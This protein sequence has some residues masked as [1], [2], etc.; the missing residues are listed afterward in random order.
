MT[1]TAMRVVAYDGSPASAA[2]LVIATQQGDARVMVK[3]T[4]IA[5]RTL[6]RVLEDC[7]GSLGRRG[8]PTH[9]EPAW[10]DHIRVDKDAEPATTLSDDAMQALYDWA[11]AR[12]E[13][14]P[15]EVLATAGVH[16]CA[17]ARELQQ[18]V[19]DHDAC[20]VCDDFKKASEAHGVYLH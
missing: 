8:D 9:G 19:C 5:H 2:E 16:V 11:L 3:L 12:D 15:D 14:R 7:G 4:D 18:L 17:Q 20:S 10:V 1:T 6:P 13:E